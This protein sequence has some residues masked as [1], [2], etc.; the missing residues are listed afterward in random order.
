MCTRTDILSTL[1]YFDIFDYPLKKREII[2][3]LPNACAEGQ[4]QTG[5][6]ELLTTSAIFKMGE[7]YS[8]QNNYNILQ[9]RTKGNERARQ[10]MVTAQKVA[11][12]LSK[13]PFTRGV[14]VSGSLSK[15]FADESS[16]IDFFIITAKNR[17]WIARTFMYILVRL[18]MIFN[19][20]N[21]FCI[22]YFIDEEQLEIEEKNIYTATEIV[23]LI[24]LYGSEIFNSFFLANN[25]TQKFLP[26]NYLRISIEK[27]AAFSPCKW[28]IEKV[29]SNK[30]GNNLDTFLM[31]ITSKRWERDTQL[32]KINKNGLLFSMKTGKHY[33]KHD[34]VIFQSRVLGLHA[35]KLFAVLNQETVRQILI[36]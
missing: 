10:M 29:F 1:A 21:F 25:W 19:K 32:K 3:F 7:F 26:N 2:L 11:A 4:F 30:Y 35:N 31:K 5:L 33:A 24:P 23:T 9:R 8:L 14:A 15:N 13:F 6:H 27:N 34:P 36:S 17:L 16:D 18:A 12:F 20:E 22:N 28:L